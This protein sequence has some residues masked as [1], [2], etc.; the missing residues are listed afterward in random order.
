MLSVLFVLLAGSKLA[1]SYDRPG[2]VTGLGYYLPTQNTDP[3]IIEALSRPRYI[4][5][6]AFTGFNASYPLSNQFSGTLDSSHTW[7]LDIAF[8]TTNVSN[9]TVEVYQ[10]A[11]DYAGE[12]YPNDMYPLNSSDW[13]ICTS[14]IQGSFAPQVLR[15]SGNDSDASCVP[16]LG[17]ACVDAWIMA[18]NA[19]PIDESTGCR[20]APSPYNIQQCKNVVTDGSFG[21]ASAG[22]SVPVSLKPS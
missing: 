8:S 15:A 13:Q 12:R 17:Q 3:A 14:I 10:Y 5:S 20:S 22:E 7:H 18:Y 9:S 4:N 11:V 19:A 16:Y 21:I 6:V 2:N 1:Y